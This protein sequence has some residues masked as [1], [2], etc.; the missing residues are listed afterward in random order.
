MKKRISKTER[1][2]DIRIKNNVRYAYMVDYD[3]FDDTYNHN[4]YAYKAKRCHN[5]FTK[6]SNLYLFFNGVLI[7]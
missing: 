6:Q 5:T 3:F 7:E 1:Y 4:C 2:S